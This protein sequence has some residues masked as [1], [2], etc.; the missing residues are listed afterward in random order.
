MYQKT[1][2]HSQEALLSEKSKIWG[3]MYY[4]MP[5]VKGTLTSHMCVGLCAFVQSWAKQRELWQ[6]VSTTVT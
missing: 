6:D 3:N 1:W 2:S 5:F 4:T